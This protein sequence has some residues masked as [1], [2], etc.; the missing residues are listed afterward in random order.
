MPGTDEAADDASGASDSEP[1][2]QVVTDR[3]DEVFLV[4]GLAAVALTL[5][6]AVFLSGYM[7]ARPSGADTGAADA[8]PS[9]TRR[10]HP[11]GRKVRDT[12]RHFHV[13][14]ANAYTGAD[15]E[16]RHQPPTALGTDLTVL[17]CRPTVTACHRFP[18]HITSCARRAKGMVMTQTPARCR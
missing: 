11:S 7:R 3:S 1:E 4:I 10:P 18:C 14:L 2:Q 12:E 5:V 16:V 6:M 17:C 8:S 9:A 15:L 13:S